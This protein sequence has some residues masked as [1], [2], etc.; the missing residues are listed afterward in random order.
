MVKVQG[1]AEMVKA[2]KKAARKPKLKVGQ[3]GGADARFKIIA[4]NRGKVCFPNLI[5]S[6]FEETLK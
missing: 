2:Q 4:K 1:F 3:K 5:M 6:A